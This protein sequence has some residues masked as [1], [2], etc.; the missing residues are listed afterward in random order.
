VKKILKKIYMC[1]RHPIFSFKF[2]ALRRNIVMIGKQYINKNKYLSISENVRIGKNARIDFYKQNS[3][4]PKI[5]IGNDVYIGD[6]LTILCAESIYIEDEVLIA[7]HVLIT[8]EN[9]GIDPLV[10]IRYGLQ[11]LKTK[12]VKILSGTWIGEKAIILPGVEIGKKCIIA[13]G[14]VVTK[15]VPNFSIVA[16]NPARVIKQFD[17]EKKI[18]KIV[19]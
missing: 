17:F 6:Y 11:P 7:S 5:H 19:G 13:A 9:H 2:K 10:D 12:A 8:D 15:S 3:A 14:S 16:G 4:D 1:I 18:W